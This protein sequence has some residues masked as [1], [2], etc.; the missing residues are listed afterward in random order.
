MWEGEAKRKSCEGRKKGRKAEGPLFRRSLRH[1]RILSFCRLK[2]KSLTERKSITTLRWFHLRNWVMTSPRLIT[3]FSVVLTANLRVKAWY[4]LSVKENF[5]LHV[6]AKPALISMKS[7]TQLL[8]FYSCH[9]TLAK[10]NSCHCEFG[11]ARNSIISSNLSHNQR[12]L[13]W[14]RPWWK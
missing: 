4:F 6:P 10:R 8:E 5:N 7:V 14:F 13:R 9:R 2:R 11:L 3:R 12:I 1:V